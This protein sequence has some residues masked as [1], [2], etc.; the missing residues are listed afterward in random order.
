MVC[1]DASNAE[2]CGSIFKAKRR[3][4]GKSLAYVAPSLAV[5]EQ[6]FQLGAEARKLAQQFW[7]GDLALLLPWRH[8]ED[9][10]QHTAVGSPGLATVASGV[11]GELAARTAVPVAA[12]TANISGDAGP[13][14][15]GPAVTLD[16]VHD[17]LAASGVTAPV[18]V[19]GGICPA[20]N[21]MT[22]VDCFT[23]EARVVRTGLVH[24]RALAAA[25]G[26]ELRRS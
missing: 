17:F 24:Q 25:L 7:P 23:A 11:L 20:A 16:E 3:P 1:A 8:P 2:A 21:H 4:S 6:R 10:A 5:C 9:A 18:I 26:R 15:R 13:E 19:D 12:T 14:D 22:I